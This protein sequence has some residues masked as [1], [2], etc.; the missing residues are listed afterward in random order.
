MNELNDYVKS[1]ASYLTSLY[2][3]MTCILL[4]SCFIYGMLLYLPGNILIYVGFIPFIICLLP[5]IISRPVLT[6]V[7]KE[8]IRCSLLLI[9]TILLVRNL[10]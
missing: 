10:L 6:Y 9:I 1:E 3:I 8:P 4:F 7:K 5:F 2:I